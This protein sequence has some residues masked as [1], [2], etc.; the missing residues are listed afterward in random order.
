M[1][2]Q[3]IFFFFCLD[4]ALNWRVISIIAV[5]SFSGKQTLLNK[6][7]GHCLWRGKVASRAY[8]SSVGQQ[9]GPV[10]RE[11]DRQRKN[12]V[13]SQCWP[14]CLSLLF[15]QTKTY[16]W[17][18]LPTYTISNRSFF[19]KSFVWPQSNVTSWNFI[20]SACGTGLSYC[21]ICKCGLSGFMRVKL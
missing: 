2:L 10:E 14:Q 20:R 6:A 4:L 9:S 7:S 13:C 11:G 8:C 21:H 12:S 1:L 17:F 5:F 16:L 15:A 18:H 3:P 19:I